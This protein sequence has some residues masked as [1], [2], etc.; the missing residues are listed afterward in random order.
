MWR[1]CPLPRGPWGWVYNGPSFEPVCEES[2]ECKSALPPTKTMIKTLCARMSFHSLSL[3]VRIR[4][5]HDALPI[6]AWTVAFV[7]DRVIDSHRK[8][9]YHLP[10][11][12]GFVSDS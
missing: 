8:M 10:P 7:S 9:S 5:A 6:F 12:L 2:E 1:K 11:E 3:K 4:V